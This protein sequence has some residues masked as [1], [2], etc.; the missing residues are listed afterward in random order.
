MTAIRFQADADLRQAIV[1]G[2]LRRQPKLNFCSATEAGLEG[3]K[4]SDVLAIAA[5]DSRVL[6][7]HD[8]KTMPTK[9]GQFIASQTSSGVLILSQNLP[10]SEAIDAIILIWEA[11]TPEEWSN[12]IMMFP[13]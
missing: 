10:I 1:T 2:T 5:Q 7:T 9:F 8:R 6:V 11:S 12:Q 3:I 13:F 4:D